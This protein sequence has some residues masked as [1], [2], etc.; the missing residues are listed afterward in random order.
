MIECLLTLHEI[1]RYKEEK[2]EAER[3]A[4]ELSSLFLSQNKMKE[5]NEWSHRAKKVAEGEP[6]N[7]VVVRVG[8]QIVEVDGVICFCFSAHRQSLN[9]HH[10]E[11]ISR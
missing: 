8:G 1:Y 6:L 7:R 4:L 9:Q 3:V 11:V 2:E 5:A 10:S